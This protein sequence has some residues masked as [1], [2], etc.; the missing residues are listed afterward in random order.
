MLGGALAAAFVLLA[1]L[2]GL[3]AVVRA[4]E[5]TATATTAQ[6]ASQQGAAE[7]DIERAYEQASQQ[8][9][10]VRALNLAIGSAQADQIA[11]KALA[12]LKTLRHNAYV[13]LAQVVGLVGNDNE[14]Y[15][16][17]TEGKFD[18]TP[19]AAGPSPTPVLLAPRLYT[20]VS[21]MSELATQLADQATNALTAPAPS[22]PPSATPAA[23]PSRAPSPSPS[24]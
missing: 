2:V 23:S 13:S 14:N 22:A 10:K 6:L 5:P 20:I 1:V 4:N 12:D 8:V 16:T 21:R 24:R 3:A 9:V 19:L 18:K 11:S 15:A 7:R 17:A